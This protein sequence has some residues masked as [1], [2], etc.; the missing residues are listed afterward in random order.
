M[1][2]QT[3]ALAGKSPSMHGR[4]EPSNNTGCL[5]CGTCCRKG[6]PGLHRRDADLYTRAILGRRDL[7]T[8]RSGE[9]IYDNVR[10]ELA[11][12]EQEMIRVRSA[13][14]GSC[15]FLR[16]GNACSIYETRPT[17]CRALQCWDTRELERLYARDRLSRFDLL[18]P[19]SAMRAI[20]DEHEQCCPYSRVGELAE[21]V[22]QGDRGSPYRELAEMAEI[23][24]R[25]RDY[26]REKA[27][28]DRLVLDFLLGR[29]L[30]ETLPLLGVRA[31]R[32]L[33]GIR[34][35]PRQVRG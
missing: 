5:R 29:A 10:G 25:F 15:P 19:E 2:Q 16:D 33:D 32:S 8:L 20:V 22:R 30:T 11:V 26:L 35:Y 23:D 6:P 18:D 17:E 13:P 27:G 14:D 1:G 34:L 28:A 3:G 31:E 24:A 9:W 21:A 4:S 7:L 12:L